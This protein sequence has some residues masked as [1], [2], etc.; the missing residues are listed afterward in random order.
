MQFHA[1]GIVKEEWL[2]IT[3]HQPHTVCSTVLNLIERLGREEHKQQLAN[4]Q[5]A[6]LRKAAPLDRSPVAPCAYQQ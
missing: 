5:K 4:L 6:L 3:S 2:Q 1:A